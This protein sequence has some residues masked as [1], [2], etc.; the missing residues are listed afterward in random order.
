M[1]RQ[2]GR[3]AIHNAQLEAEVLDRLSRMSMVKVCDM[4][5]M[6]NRSTIY[7][8]MDNVPGFSD[9][10][11]RACSERADH[12]AEMIDDIAERCLSGEVDPQAARVA[13]DAHK[14]TASK[15]KPK[16]YGERLDLGNADGKPFSIELVKEFVPQ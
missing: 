14:W 1:G 16:K 7:L 4:T 5:D 2:A 8:W 10:Y 15:L 12:R 3:P 11:A 6:P 9:K 13:I